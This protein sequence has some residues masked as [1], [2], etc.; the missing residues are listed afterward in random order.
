MT[1]QA[2]HKLIR[3]LTKFPIQNIWKGQKDKVTYLCAFFQAFFKIKITFRSVNSRCTLNEDSFILKFKSTQQ[4]FLY[5]LSLWGIAS[6]FEQTR[7]ND[8]ISQWPHWHLSPESLK[9]KIKCCNLL[10]NQNMM[11]S[12]QQSFVWNGISITKYLLMLLSSS[13]TQNALTNPAKWPKFWIAT[14]TCYLK[15]VM[16][17]WWEFFI[18]V[19]WKIGVIKQVL[20]SLSTKSLIMTHTK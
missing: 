18:K 15:Q 4:N 6:N 13:I 7:W 9:E 2:A 10:Y 11:W 8:G 5:V 14:R 19:E 20:T 16:S 17:N 1:F 12:Y 3:Y